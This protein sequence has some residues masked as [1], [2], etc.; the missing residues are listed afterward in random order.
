MDTDIWTNS[1]NKSFI[2]LIGHCT[3]HDFKQ[4]VVVLNSKP[5]ENNHTGRNIARCMVEQ[6]DEWKIPIY[7]VH[8]VLHDNASNM[9]CGIDNISPYQSLPCFIHTTQLVI[10][11]TILTQ[12]VVVNVLAKCRALNTNLRKSPPNRAIFDQHLTALKFPKKWVLLEIWK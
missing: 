4:Q 11:D 9:V 8:N 12:P 1:A 10:K 6:V 5:F 2:S 3:F 7:K